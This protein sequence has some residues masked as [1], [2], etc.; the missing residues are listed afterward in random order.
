MKTK[1]N[2]TKKTFDAVKSMR[3]IRDKISLEIAD[4]N[5]LLCQGRQT[6]AA[7]LPRGD[8]LSNCSFLRPSSFTMS[9]IIW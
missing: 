8:Y 4:M 7:C 5:F 6:E 1:S 2:K 9:R 3:E